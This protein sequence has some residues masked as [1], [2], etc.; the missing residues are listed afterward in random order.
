MDSQPSVSTSAVGRP[1]QRQDPRAHHEH[2]GRQ[3]RPRHWFGI[4]VRPI[5]HVQLSKVY[6]THHPLAA[7]RDVP[8]L[9]VDEVSFAAG[10]P[11]T[12]L[13]APKLPGPDERAV[14]TGNA[15]G[16]GST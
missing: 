13:R 1:F 3:G 15:R 10:V 11:E 9:G 16:V 8:L 12:F 6:A 14:Q 7:G 2:G 5:D 4:S